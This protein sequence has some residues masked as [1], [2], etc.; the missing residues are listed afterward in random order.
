MTTKFGKVPVITEVL[1]Y[2]APNVKRD[3]VETVRK[4][5]LDELAEIAEILPDSYNGSYLYET[6]RITRAGALALR[7]RAALYFG[8]YAEAEASA[9]K[10]YLKDIIL[11]SVYHRLPPHSKKKLTKWMHILTMQPKVSIKI[12]S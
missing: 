6:G 3:E 8:N 5:I 4:F 2:D 12:N 11:Y 7:A 1:A 9:G 10:S